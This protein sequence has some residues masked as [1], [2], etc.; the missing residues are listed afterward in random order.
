M[1]AATQS[2]RDFFFAQK[3]APFFP[4]TLLGQNIYF[5]LFFDV[6]GKGPFF[7][8]KITF[9]KNVISPEK[10]R[11]ASS[12]ETGALWIEFPIS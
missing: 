5:L 9:T 11:K 3:K 1:K 4:W 8:D 10:E 6:T 7:L 2:Q 12:L